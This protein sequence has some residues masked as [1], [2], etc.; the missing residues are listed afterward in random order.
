[1]SM[2][3]IQHLNEI[4]TDFYSDDRLHNG[5]ISLYLAVF[6]Y[7]NLHYFQDGFYANRTE[8][9]QM[10]KIGSRSTYHRLIKELSE[11]G[12]IEYLPSRNPKQYSMVRVSHN[13]T[14]IGTILERTRTIFD[15]YC[16][17]TVPAS[18]YN[19]QI[20]QNKG[21]VHRKPKDKLICLDY[22]KKKKYPSIEAE[23]FFNHYEAI[24]WKI[25]G[26]AAIVQWKSAADNWM[27][28]SKEITNAKS[29]N[30]VSHPASIEASS[31]HG[32]DYLQINNKKNYAEPL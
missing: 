1:M 20:K 11:F 2:N 24:G 32:N 23:K 15:T 25:G 12:Y 27:L 6:Y 3:Y 4:F 10:A 21:S 17:V 26:K 30:V 22:F 13:C 29:K 19:K 14:D 18:L 7:W 31:T 16:P 8:L 5:H 28:K 9:M